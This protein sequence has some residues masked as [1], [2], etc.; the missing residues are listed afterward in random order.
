MMMMVE[1]GSE[2]P[3]GR[4]DVHCVND[5]GGKV[6]KERKKRWMGRVGDAGQLDRCIDCME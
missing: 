3:R 1:G 4:A 6:I 2:T 5:G